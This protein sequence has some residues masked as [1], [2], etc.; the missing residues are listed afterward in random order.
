[1]PMRYRRLSA[2]FLRPSILPRTVRLDQPWDVAF[3]PTAPRAWRPAV[4]ACESADRLVVV[5]DLAGIDEDRTEV[6]LFADALVVEGERHV[7]VCASD[8]WYDR[9]EIRQ[10]P[11]RLEMGLPFPVDPE[12]VEASY[13][14]G[15][16]RI[17]LQRAAPVSVEVSGWNEAPDRRGEAR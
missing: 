15:L 13:E 6:T 12:R 10:G 9:A 17:T 5:A 14:R 1:M 7:D 16:L 2:R 3:V 8:G 4:D 11:F